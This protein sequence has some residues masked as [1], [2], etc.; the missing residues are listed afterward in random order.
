MPKTGGTFVHGVFKKIIERFR[1]EHS[2]QWYLN[3]IGYKMQL[4]IPIYQK[5]SNVAYSEYPNNNV[6]GQHAG[7]SFIPKEYQKLPVISVKRDPIKKFISTY[8]F[9]WWERFPSLPLEQLT[10]LF[11][12]YPEI[13]ID[14][15]FELSNHHEMMHFFGNDYR[16]DI[17][18]LSW[19]FIRMYSKNPIFV[20]RNI[21]QA[22]YQE[23]IATYFI[24]V[25]FF[26]MDKLSSEFESYVQTT[27]FAAF[28][29]YFKTEDRIYPPGSNL[30]KRTEEISES[31]TAKIKAKEWILYKFFPEYN[32]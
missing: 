18:V 9:R 19:Q 13:S 16:D 1:K 10:T 12:Q 14:E 4:R 2:F 25:Q 20:Y 30:R 21:T 31:L 28:S 6:E 23:L 3:R 24:N 26:E 17:G 8:Y 29:N 11:P 32:L 15:Y 22:N 7:V 5:L 27:R